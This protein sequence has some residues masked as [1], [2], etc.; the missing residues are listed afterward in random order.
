MAIIY[1]YPTAI[2]TLTDLLLGTDVDKSGKPTKNFTIQSVVELIQGSAAG[3]G[4]TLTLSNDAR[5]VNT[6]GT[7][8]ANQSAINFANITGT[9]NVSGFT[10]FSTAGGANINGTTGTGFT[11]F[12]STSIT[13]TLLTSAQPNITSVGTLTSLSVN[14]SVTGTAVVTTLVA[15]GDNL[16]IASTKAIIDY[17]ALK[18]NKET[19]AETLGAGELSGGA[20][21]IVMQGAISN[22][23][24]EDSDATGTKGRALFGNKVGGDL[25][26]HHDGTDSFVTD[27]STGD[28]RLRSDDAVK[29]QAST[30][31]NTLAT[32]T[33]AAG[34]DLYF[35]NAKIFETLVGG[36]K[37]TG[38]FEATTSGTFAS[39]VNTGTY[40]AGNGV[41]AAG[42]ILSST[43]TGTSWVTEVPL[44]SWIIEADLDD[45]GGANTPYTVA[46]GD[47]ID[48]RGVG[49][50]QTEWDLG[51]KELRIS[52]L[53]QITGGG[54]DGQVTFWDG[55][56]T[57]DGNA[58]MTYDAA[59]FDLTV[60]NII[61]ADT[62][63]TTAGTATWVTTVL[64]G[65]TSITSALFIGNAAASL[66]PPIPPFAVGAADNVQFQGNASTANQL[67]FGGT[68]GTS[69]DVTTVTA[70]TY[71]SGGS[72]LI[73]TTIAD[74]I[75]TGK[76]LTNLPTPTSSG[77]LNTDTIL[78]AMAKLQGQITATS[79]LTYEGL[80]NA[81][82]DSPALSG[83]TPANGVFYIVDVA[84]NTSLSGI[85]DWLVGDW[86]IYV[87]NGS[88]T[89]GWQKLDMTSDIT[90][91]GSANSY[92]MWTGP[93]SVATGLISQ[94]AGANL[95]TIGNSGGLLVEGSTTLG[96]A[97]TDT[98]TVTGN[99]TLNENL[100]LTKGLSI[101]S[102]AD[103]YGAS[104]QALISGGG[105]NIANTWVDLTV[106]T[107]TSVGL[108]ETGD[109]LTI[110]GSPVTSSGTIN[111]AG[112]GASTDY[113]N[114]ELNLVAFPTLSGTQY[115]LPMF[116]T[117]ST[118][119]DSMF[120]QNAGGTQG[121]ISGA[122]KIEGDLDMDSYKIEEVDELKFTNNKYIYG[123]G[124]A[125]KV[126]GEFRVSDESTFSNLVTLDLINNATTDTD[127]FLVSDSGEI[128]YRTGA[129]VLSDIGAA[130]ATG[131]A[132]LPLAGGTLTGALTGTDATFSG[133]VSLADDKSLTLGTGV[134]SKI[135]FD[136]AASVLA[137]S[138][139]IQSTPT[140][141]TG[142]ILLQSYNVKM[143][144]QLGTSNMFHATRYGVTL[145]YDGDVKFTTTSSG[146]NLNGFGSGTKTGTAAY[147]LGVDSA[148]DVIETNANPGG[149]G[150]GI[151]SGDQAIAFPP[152]TLGDKAFTLNR[153]TTGTL[154]F[155][156]WFTSETSTS[157]SV[158]KKYTVA[159][160]NNATPV[161]NKIIDTGP[162]G[163]NDF[164][165]S[166]VNAGS[167]LSVECYIV[168]GS[169][170]QNIGYTVQVGHDSTNALTFTP[171]S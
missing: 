127:K 149:S 137:D 21:N 83:T 25:E 151:F 126:E 26:I 170:A 37:V 110:T 113:I 167:G 121:T 135:F 5:I 101:P 133:N 92:A 144:D 148:G 46:S 129:E 59:T 19:L 68:I 102:L 116:A 62:F 81:T 49:N 152:P 51:T 61:K 88:A 94:N 17:I 39:L 158:A 2:P 16:K 71:T 80:W 29:I 134:D 105:V 79:G 99:V 55:P 100:I 104:G 58:G 107:V 41:G 139:V 98:V 52:L 24:F 54:T 65:F 66:T 72:Q 138:T 15:P 125:V 42:Q 123:T 60:T 20:K 70:P 103:P 3:L 143:R 34:V 163:S 141:G 33:K 30:G 111:I 140:S 57:I 115:T 40:T 171:A 43:G 1:S 119:G 132:Y 90:G 35:A 122:V 47:A 124:S 38:A 106:G 85:T 142:T 91:T 87:S 160:A 108:T 155:D 10:G 48:F 28:L 136:N 120:L 8:G 118:L 11:A 13:G 44:Y 150:G 117:T 6:D 162:D 9:G 22:I 4:A 154:I 12:T 56:S 50:V 164:T 153:A 89:D 18:P 145:Y 73:A 130:P 156:V 77:I 75:V 169:I 31:G 76:V 109:A 168:A 159:H 74:T 67:S 97:T 7:F 53:N 27:L 63:T 82:T 84:G 93:N 161:Y 23:T 166:F 14:T 96:D 36:A 32:F 128:K 69:G 64:D 157:T 112:A 45:G 146:V 114:G 78:A 131:G 86:A 165:V 147:N 95:V